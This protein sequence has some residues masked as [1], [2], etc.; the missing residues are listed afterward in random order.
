M[1]KGETAVEKP[2][3]NLDRLLWFDTS[4]MRPDEWQHVDLERWNEAASV[5]DAWQK[6]I[7]DARSEVKSER[8]RV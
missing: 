6:G 1:R 7:E 4:P 8:D 3:P 5:Q 2:L